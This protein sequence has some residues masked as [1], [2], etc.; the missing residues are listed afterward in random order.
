MFA[1]PI[2]HDVVRVHITLVLQRRFLSL[3]GFGV[4]IASPNPR[5]QSCQACGMVATKY[6]Q[7]PFFYEPTL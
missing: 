7:G 6:R 3:V 5:P 4:E 1:S 2:P